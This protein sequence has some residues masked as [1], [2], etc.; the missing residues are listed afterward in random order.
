[1][2]EQPDPDAYADP[3]LKDQVGVLPRFFCA[4]CSPPR[5]LPA[6]ES[7]QCLD[8]DAPCFKNSGTA[9]PPPVE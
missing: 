5:S 2:I 4:Q 6:G 9:Y 1:M 8:R 7:V 3:S